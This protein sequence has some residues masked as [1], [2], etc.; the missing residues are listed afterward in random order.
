MRG[1]LKADMLYRAR[2]LTRGGARP[3]FTDLHPAMRWRLDVPAIDY[4]IDVTGHGLCL[5]PCLFVRSTVPPI[6]ADEPPSP[7][8][9]ARGT[10]TLWE[11]EPPTGG[12]A[13]VALIGRRKAALLGC[14]DR[15]RRWT[16]P[17]G[18]ASLPERSPGT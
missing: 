2:Q 5:M 6:S 16:W 8:C 14:P 11:T 7:A 1:V 12:E 18:S 17:N 3:L 10:A 15:P 9:P 13:I 4:R